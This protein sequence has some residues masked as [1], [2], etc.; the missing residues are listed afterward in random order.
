MNLEHLSMSLALLGGVTLSS[1]CVSTK[2]CTEVGCSDQF[3]A[4]IETTSASLPPG[5]HRL[6]VT[7]D[8]TTLSCTFSVPVEPIPSEGLPSP[9]C[10]LGLT[11]FVGPA[12]TCTTVDNG[13][14]KSQS[15]DPVPDRIKESLRITRSP[16]HLTVTQWAGDTM[17]FEQTAIPTYQTSQPNGPGCEPICRQASASWSIP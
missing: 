4:T 9:D 10:P 1:S 15:C 11:L 17:I 7:A 13:T 8:G 5:A 12:V 2:A 16:T 14:A 6:D 3:S